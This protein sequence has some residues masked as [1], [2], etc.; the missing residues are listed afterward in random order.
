MKKV[1][2]LI[3]K[4]IFDNNAKAFLARLERQGY[5]YQ[6]TS[7]LKFHP[8]EAENFFGRDEC[9]LF[10]GSLN[11]GRD[12]LKT[13][14]L[15]GAYMNERNLR[16]SMYYTYFGNYLLNDR[17]FMLSLGELRSCF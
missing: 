15:P 14:W 7:Y 16:C 10:R 6:E 8:N 3:E 2:W 17:Y 5:T 1:N 11:L 4:S 13:S 12:V 9:V